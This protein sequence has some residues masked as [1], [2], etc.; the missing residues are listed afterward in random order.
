VIVAHTS[1]AISAKAAD[2]ASAKATTHVA[3]AKPAT[4]VASAEPPTHVASTT[5]ATAASASLCTRGKKAAGEQ[6]ARQNHHRSSS[7]DIL[8]LVGRTCRHRTGFRRCSSQVT[9]NVA[10]KERWECLFVVSTKISF[11]QTELMQPGRM[12]A[13]SRRDRSVGWVRHDFGSKKL[14]GAHRPHEGD[15]VRRAPSTRQPHDLA[16]GDRRGC[17]GSDLGLQK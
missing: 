12:R 17:T 9:S 15:E 10:M 3:S 7:H 14:D 5:S 13:R 6:R 2:A 8:H 1:D 4:H 11:I 16:S